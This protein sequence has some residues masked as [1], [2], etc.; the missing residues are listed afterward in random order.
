M[1]G[2][3][4]MEKYLDSSRSPWYSLI[5]VLPLWLLYEILVVAVNLG[6]R[7]QI[8]NG[9]D[10]LLRSALSVLGV[11]GRLG[12]MLVLAGVAA[13]W[14]Y[15]ADAGHR[16]QPLHPTYFAGMLA[17]SLVYALLFGGVVVSLMQLFI[18]GF[19]LRLQ[20]GGIEQLNFGM[21]FMTSLG[22]GVYEELVFRVLLMGGLA[23]AGQ[24]FLKMKPGAALLAAMLLSS[25]A[26]SAIHYVGA[27]GDPFRLAS[28]SFRFFAGMVLAVIYR[29][30]GFGIA[31]YTHAFYDVILLMQKGG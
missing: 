11:E 25:L 14:V 23:L 10:A 26:F 20:V 30:R 31:A 24:R 7:A 2:G 22:A 8:S 6:S 28:F 9:A 3:L 1:S 15:R 16:K 21:K 4:A 19:L 18:P 12:G 27:L 5:F 13:V 29:L 17:E